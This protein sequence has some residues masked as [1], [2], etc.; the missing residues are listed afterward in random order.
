MAREQ[1]VNDNLRPPNTAAS[2]DYS[3]PAE[4]FMLQA[5]ATRGRAM[6]YRRFQSAAEAIHFAVEEVPA[7]LLVSV[8]MEV[9]EE[10]FDHKAIRELYARDDYPL[11]R[12]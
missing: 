8:V 9:R 2:F 3:A 5:R 4:I 1:P 11:T 7:S 10:R 12:R 6:G